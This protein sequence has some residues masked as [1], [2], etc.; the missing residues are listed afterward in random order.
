[1]RRDECPDCWHRWKYHGPDGSNG[2]GAPGCR[3]TEP[4]ALDQFRC[5]DGSLVHDFKG[6]TS[7]PACGFA[8]FKPREVA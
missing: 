5:A 8:G 3:C 6:G 7:C 4:D 1:M 2:C